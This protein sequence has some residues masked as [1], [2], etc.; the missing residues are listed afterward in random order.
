MQYTGIC[1]IKSISLILINLVYLLVFHK[2]I[3]TLLH[4]FFRKRL[5]L[6]TLHSNLENQSQ[7]PKSNRIYNYKWLIQSG[8]G[9]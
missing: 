3:G 7:G 9:F 1:I 6:N 5:A 4:Y 2:K 8:G